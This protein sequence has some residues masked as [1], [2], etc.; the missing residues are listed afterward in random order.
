MRHIADNNNKG[1]KQP[2]AGLEK[3]KDGRKRIKKGQ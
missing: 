3:Q 2:D 1:D